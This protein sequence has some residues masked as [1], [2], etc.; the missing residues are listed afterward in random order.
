[1]YVKLVAV[2]EITE[3]SNR[4]TRPLTVEFD[5]VSTV[6]QVNAEDIAKIDV[7]SCHQAIDVMSNVIVAM[8]NPTLLIKMGW[9]GSKDNITFKS[10][11]DV[12]RNYSY[13]HNSDVEVRA[14]GVMLM[15]AH[16]WFPKSKPQ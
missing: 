12:Y 6:G 8:K 15:L 9:A 10:V 13:D 7:L 16:E 11:L 1:M 3:V 4:H 5:A 2:S 14:L